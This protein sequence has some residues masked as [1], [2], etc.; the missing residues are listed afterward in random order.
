MMPGSRKVGGGPEEAHG[1]C[2]SVCSQDACA[3]DLDKT[4]VFLSFVGGLPLRHRIGLQRLTFLNF[5]QI[6]SRPSHNSPLNRSVLGSTKQK[7]NFFIKN[8]SLSPAIIVSQW[9]CESVGELHSID[10]YFFDA[11]PPY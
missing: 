5:F 11:G 2:I 4:R 10:M 1:V 9:L 7:T 6:K 8:N 3:V